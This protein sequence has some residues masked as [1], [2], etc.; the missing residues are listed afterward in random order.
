[1][2][3]SEMNLV[4]AALAFTLLFPAAVAAQSTTARIDQLPGRIVGRL[5][6]AETGEAVEAAEI[7]IPDLPGSG[8]LSD[9]DGRFI[10]TD[11]PRGV[12]VL[13]IK[14]LA[15]GRGSHSVNVPPGET[16]EL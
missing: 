12:H 5:L 14:H 11:V 15:Y 9:D 10:V 13:E 16:V 6:D 8:R 1:M 3:R 7:R 2:D 4:A